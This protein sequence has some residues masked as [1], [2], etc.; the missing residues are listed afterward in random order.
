MISFKV[1]IR[2]V[3]VRPAVSMG[4]VESTAENILSARSTLAGYPI[5]ISR[6][7]T[8]EWRTGGFWPKT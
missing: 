6:Q 5:A 8:S 3:P 4:S 1:Y 7:I 2:A